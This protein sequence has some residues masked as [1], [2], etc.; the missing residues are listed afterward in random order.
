MQAGKNGGNSSDSGAKQS[1]LQLQLSTQEHTPSSAD[2]L[3]SPFG[4]PLQHLGS[5]NASKMQTLSVQM[6]RVPGIKSS[7]DSLALLDYDDSELNELDP[8]IASCLK[9]PNL[10]D[11]DDEIAISEV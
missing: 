2:F 8:V 9:S 4:L 11:T 6:G 1:Q 7:I 10:S 5:S 3:A